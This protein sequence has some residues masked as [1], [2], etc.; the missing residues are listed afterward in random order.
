M[1]GG[2]TRTYAA[3]N[4]KRETKMQKNVEDHQNNHNFL[5]KDQNPI[6]QEVLGSGFEEL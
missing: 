5:R 1:T 3:K 2:K 4:T 6:L